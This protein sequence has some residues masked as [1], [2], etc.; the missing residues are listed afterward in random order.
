MDA[1]REVVKAIAQ[2]GMTYEEIEGLIRILGS[3]RKEV[4]P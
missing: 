4:G 2:A 1:L 3:C